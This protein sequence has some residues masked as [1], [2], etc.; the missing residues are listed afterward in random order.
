MESSGLRYIPNLIERNTTL[1]SWVYACHK[2]AA[3]R[4]RFKPE[5]SPKQGCLAGAIRANQ[6][7]D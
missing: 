6:S 5:Q 7:G 3:A 2:N 1:T 4:R